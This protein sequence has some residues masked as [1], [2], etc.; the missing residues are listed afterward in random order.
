VR[1]RRTFILFALG[2]LLV[3]AAHLVV[4]RPPAAVV[5]R[6]WWLSLVAGATLLAALVVNEIFIWHDLA[7]FAFEACWVAIGLVAYRRTSDG[8]PS[9]RP[10]ARP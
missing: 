1:C 10:A 4:A 9:L 2:F 8:E 5:G 6:L 3:F 7:L